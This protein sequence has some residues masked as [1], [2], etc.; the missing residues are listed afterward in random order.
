MP[1]L[2]TYYGVRAVKFSRLLNTCERLASTIDKICS[3]L[4]PITKV[5]GTYVTFTVAE[6]STKGG[7]GGC[8]MYPKE[9]PLNRNRFVTRCKAFLYKKL[10]TLVIIHV[11]QDV[12]DFN[13]TSF[14]RNQTG[15]GN[16]YDFSARSGYGI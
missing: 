16:S 8:P 1:F 11:D 15:A 4:S 5:F 2:L 3:F 9:Y 12:T 14:M 6:C 7:W 10:F 13:G